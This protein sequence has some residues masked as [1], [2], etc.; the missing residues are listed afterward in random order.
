VLE[1][2]GIDPEETPFCAQIWQW[3]A[4]RVP[5]WVI[6][7]NMEARAMFFDEKEM[8]C[9]TATPNPPPDWMPPLPGGILEMADARPKYP[10]PKR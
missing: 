6:T 5:G 4:R 7:D 9:L 3:S 2:L 1:V 10:Q 8:A